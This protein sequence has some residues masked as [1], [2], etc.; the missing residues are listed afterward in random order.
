VFEGKGKV[1]WRKILPL[2]NKIEKNEEIG[3]GQNNRKSHCLRLF[4][5]EG[6]LKFRIDQ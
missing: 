4:Q 3:I 5:R 6:M 1:F 2:K